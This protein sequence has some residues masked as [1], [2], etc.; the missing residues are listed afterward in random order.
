MVINSHFDL[1]F[2]N[3]LAGPQVNFMSPS[4]FQPQ[5]GEYNPNLRQIFHHVAEQTGNK[6][7]VHE[8]V[9]A[10]VTGPTFET[11]PDCQALRI[12]GINAVGMSTVPEVIVAAN[13][14]METC[15]FSLITNV[16]AEDGTNATSH[17]EVMAALQNPITKSRVS[18]II[19]EFFRNLPLFD[20]QIAY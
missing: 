20:D 7:H 14:G 11:S 2:P 13:I 6:K 15:G 17:D 5:H 12:L 1:F 9:Y 10:A 4:R 8:G 16:I 18:T 19:R 3:P